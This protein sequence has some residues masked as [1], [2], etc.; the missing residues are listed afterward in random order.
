MFWKTQPLRLKVEIT[1]HLL[2]LGESFQLSLKEKLSF[3]YLFNM[4]IV[5]GP[6]CLLIRCSASRVL[7]LELVIVYS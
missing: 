7:I 5:P 4:L 3:P 6:T 1:M 2:N